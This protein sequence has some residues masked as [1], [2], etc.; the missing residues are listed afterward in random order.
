MGKALGKQVY[1]QPSI[2]LKWLN[3]RCKEIAGRYRE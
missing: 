1:T 2:F 3:Q